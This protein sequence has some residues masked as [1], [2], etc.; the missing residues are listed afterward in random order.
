MNRLDPIH[1][2]VRLPGYF[3]FYLGLSELVEHNL[4]DRAWNYWAIACREILSRPCAFSFSFPSLF[5]RDTCK[6]NVALVRSLYHNIIDYLIP[7]Y[8]RLNGFG[9]PSSYADQNQYDTQPRQSS[10]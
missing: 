5:L 8:Q 1:A 6:S 2:P 7:I 9:I 4:L 10:L 3:H